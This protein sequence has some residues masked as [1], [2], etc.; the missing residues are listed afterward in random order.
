MANSLIERL[1]YPRQFGEGL[2]FQPLQGQEP[3]WW[4]RPVDKIV[5][6]SRCH[7]PLL[8][9]PVQLVRAQ[10]A[11]KWAPRCPGCAQDAA[12]NRR[13]NIDDPLWWVYLS[14]E[15]ALNRCKDQY[16]APYTML[17]AQWRETLAQV[18]QDDWL[19]KQLLHYMNLSSREKEGELQEVVRLAG[20]A[21][22][23]AGGWKELLRYKA[24]SYV[25]SMRRLEE[26]LR[27]Y[28]SSPPIFPLILYL[29]KQD[30]EAPPLLIEQEAYRWIEEHP[31]VLGG[32]SL[33]KETPATERQS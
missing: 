6:C 2:L 5:M 32:H 22:G 3:I 31:L 20:A 28:A 8:H 19:V 16:F 13:L 30:E 25:L 18:E 26:W 11:H 33:K 23:V 10:R 17:V 29:L 12:D 4:Y 27:Q 1:F 21:L 14:P 9:T 15:E 24:V 7:L